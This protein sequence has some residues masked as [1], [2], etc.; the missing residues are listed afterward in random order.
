MKMK[1]KKAR[2]KKKLEVKEL[3]KKVVPSSGKKPL[4]MPYAPGTAYGLARRV[5]LEAWPERKGTT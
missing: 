2:R 5:N 1:K 3:E 4:P